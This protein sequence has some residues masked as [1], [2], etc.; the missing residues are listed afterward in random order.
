MANFHF[1]DA[2]TMTKL[3]LPLSWSVCLELVRTILSVKMLG[4]LRV[5]SRF[6]SGLTHLL[7][8]VLLALPKCPPSPH[9]SPSSPPKQ[10]SFQTISAFQYFFM[11]VC[12]HVCI[13]QHMYGVQ[14]TVCIVLLTMGV[15][16]LNSHGQSVLVGRT[17]TPG[18]IPWAGSFC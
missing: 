18:A 2:G 7:G 3:S 5:S 4:F 12:I 9:Y 14:R 6:S 1:E 15:G 13:P 17:C 11:C 10:Q 16:S 8:A